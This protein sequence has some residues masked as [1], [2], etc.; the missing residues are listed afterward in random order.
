MTKN[1]VLSGQLQDEIDILKSLK[2]SDTEQ[3]SEE[4]VPNDLHRKSNHPNQSGFL[5]LVIS[6]LKLFGLFMHR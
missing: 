5:S 4:T 6:V 1:K 2:D 3:P